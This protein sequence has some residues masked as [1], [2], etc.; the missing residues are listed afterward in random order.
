MQVTLGTRHLPIS[1]SAV[2]VCEAVVPTVICCACF[3][4]CRHISKHTL[5]SYVT[6]HGRKVLKQGNSCQTQE[7]HGKEKWS[8]VCPYRH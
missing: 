1:N 2:A 8:Q 6:R 4:S 3:L 5:Q 7:I